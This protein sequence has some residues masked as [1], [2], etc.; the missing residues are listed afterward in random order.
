MLKQSTTAQN[1]TEKNIVSVGINDVRDP[2]GKA[3]VK[4]SGTTKEAQK[5][6]E[7]I[8]KDRA[9]MTFEKYTQKQRRNDNTTIVVEYTKQGIDRYGHNFANYTLN[10]SYTV[11]DYDVNTLRVLDE[12]G[13]Y[14]NENLVTADDVSYA[15]V[16]LHSVYTGERYVDIDVQVMESVSTVSEDYFIKYDEKFYDGNVSRKTYSDREQIE[17]LFTFAIENTPEIPINNIA[18]CINVSVEFAVDTGEGLSVMEKGFWSPID[19]LPSMLKE[20]LKN[21]TK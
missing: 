11:S 20:E 8:K 17:Q 6:V 2:T 1:E 9:N 5:L 3:Y 10:E 7:A 18:P 21:I 12:L 19:A 14:E 15:V 13:F 4:F 16:T